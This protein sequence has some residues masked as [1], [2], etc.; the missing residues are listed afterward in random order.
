[1]AMETEVQTQIGNRSNDKPLEKRLRNG[2]KL[3]ERLSRSRNQPAF[4]L[5]S[6]YYSENNARHYFLASIYYWQFA[7]CA[8][9][10]S[11]KRKRKLKNCVFQGELIKTCFHFYLIF[12]IYKNDHH[13]K[14]RGIIEKIY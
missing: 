7:L 1:M 8:D 12:Y 5:C 14:Y 6:F 10:L 4:V 9:L 13:Y 3:S 11:G 2:I